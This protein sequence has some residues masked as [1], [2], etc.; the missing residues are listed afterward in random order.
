MSPVPMFPNILN[1]ATSSDN[2]FSLDCRY[3]VVEVRCPQH[4]RLSHH[5]LDE[6]C[7]APAARGDKPRTLGLFYWP[8]A[9]SRFA[10]PGKSA[11]AAAVTPSTQGGINEHQTE[12]LE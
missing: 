11:A 3:Q 8:A 10:R 5:D 1:T 2:I 7:P 9:G 6:L 12:S 4:W